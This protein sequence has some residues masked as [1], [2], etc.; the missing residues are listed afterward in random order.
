M[1]TYTDRKKT[2]L[3]QYE[4][5]SQDQLTINNKFGQVKIELW[6]KPEIQI[7][8]RIRAHSTDQH[9]VDQLLNAVTINEQREGNQLMINTAI[10]PLDGLTP[11]IGF[12]GKD[13]I[14]SSY[15]QIDYTILM[16]IENRLTLTNQFGNVHIP[17]FKAPLTVFLQNGN[18]TAN[19]LTDSEIAAKVVYGNAD[20]KKMT[21]GEVD[22][23]YGNLAVKTANR[24]KLNNKMGKFWLGKATDLTTT[25]SYSEMEIGSVHQS[26]LM[27]IRFSQR[28]HM[29][30]LPESL[31]NLDMALSYSSVVL[32]LT[33]KANYNFD[34]NMKYSSFSYPSNSSVLIQSQSTDASSVK[35]YSGIVGQGTGTKLQL[36]G[37]FSSIGFK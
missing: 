17:H 8:V 16:P 9:A 34:V 10:E 11:Y 35:R 22:V 28:F 6:K 1:A 5:Q 20:I 32:P 30:Q 19:S 2:I 36:V 21:D 29:D 24:V 4:V 15:L 25:S 27:T 7:T 23:A 33:R 14:L 26:A 31:L 12:T 13:S 37:D 18:F 3:L